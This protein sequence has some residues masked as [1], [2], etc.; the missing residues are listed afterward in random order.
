M[1]IVAVIIVMEEVVVVVVVKLVQAVS[2]LMSIHVSMSIA[3]LT[4][5][6]LM[7]SVASRLASMR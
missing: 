1:V 2:G 4:I 5:I 6:I 7:I 3:I